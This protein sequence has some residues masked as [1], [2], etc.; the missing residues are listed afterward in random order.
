MPPLPTP[1][2]ERPAAEIEGFAGRKR[3]LYAS[4]E[5]KMVEGGLGGCE[6]PGSALRLVYRIPLPHRLDGRPEFQRYNV[7]HRSPHAATKIRGA[8]Y[9]AVQ[10]YTIFITM[11]KRT[12]RVFVYNGVNPSLYG[13]FGVAKLMVFNE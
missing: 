8:I 1:A 12:R 10:A 4:R 5:M 3:R 7:N 9:L 13:G 6:A 2:P 11:F